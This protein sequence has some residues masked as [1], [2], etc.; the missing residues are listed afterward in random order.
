MENTIQPKTIPIPLDLRDELPN[1]ST[2]W[3]I[4]PRIFSEMKKQKAKHKKVQVLPTDPEWNFVWKYFHNDPP[5]Y[6]INKVYCVY[7][8]GLTKCFEDNISSA[9]SEINTPN[10]EKEPRAEQRAIV[11][12]RWEQMTKQFPFQLVKEERQ[13]KISNTKVLPFWHGSDKESC[14]SICRSGFRI[15]GKDSL[16]EKQAG[17]PKYTDKGFFGNGIYFT[18]SARYSSDIYSKDGNILLALVSIE[19]PFPVVGDSKQKDMKTL[20]GKGVYKNYNAHYIPVLPANPHPNCSAYYPCKKGEQPVCDEIVVFEKAQTLPRFWIELR[21]E[22]PDLQPVSMKSL[23]T[24]KQ[25]LS[26]QELLEKKQKEVFNKTNKLEKENLV[27]SSYPQYSKKIATSTKIKNVFARLFKFST[28]LLIPIKIGSIF[29][30]VFQ[31]PKTSSIIFTKMRNVFARIFP[32]QYRKNFIKIKDSKVTLKELKK[33]PIEEFIEAIS[34]EPANTVIYRNL[35]RVFSM[36]EKLILSDG[37]TMHKRDYFLRKIELNSDDF[38]SYNN[39]GIILYPDE[40]IDL[41]NGNKV[42]KTQ[43]FLKAIELNP[44]FF[45]A[46]NNLASNLSLNEKIIFP[47]GTEM[48][49]KDLFLKAIQLNPNNSEAYSALGLILSQNE[50]SK[51]ITFLNGNEMTQGELFLKAIKLNPDNSEAYT[52]FGASLSSDE[53]ASLNGIKMTKEDLYLKAI[54]LDAN[55][56]LPYNNLA[57]IIINGKIKLLNGNEMTKEDLYLK[58]IELN[59]KFFMPYYNLA[60]LLS[61]DTTI[62]LLNGIVMNKKDLYLKTIDLNPNLV[63]AYFNLS[64]LLS[65]YETIKL[66]NGNK[67]NKRDLYLKAIDLNPNYSYAYFHLGYLIFPSETIFLLN[68]TKMT[69]KDCFLKYK[70]LIKN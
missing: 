54:D 44:N 14:D 50:K 47:D 8:E 65:L 35:T 51:K 15:I 46:Y 26:E 37:T 30:R 32:F 12:Q 2:P 69:R 28:I 70:S 10:W 58:A 61:R 55:N 9:E 29:T 38:L 17:D 5:K 63:D 7:R 43:L 48:S 3:M 20:R 67:M 18:T 39:L 16:G 66:L 31:F 23:V 27:K 59:P 56:F 4:S 42:D 49:Q 13:W 45:I 68:G 1:P 52:F 33:I 11:M 6:A 36:N 60:R 19:K 40:E 53:V 25:I 64:N 57:N 24:E 22:G 34:K 62:Q 41:F 21:V